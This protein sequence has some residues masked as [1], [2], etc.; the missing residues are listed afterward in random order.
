RYYDPY[1]GTWLGRDKNAETGGPNPYCFVFNNPIGF[2]DDLGNDP[3]LKIPDPS[4]SCIPLP[5]GP[6]RDFTAAQRC[7][8]NEIGN[9]EGCWE[10]GRKVP[11]TA[12]GNWF[13]DHQPANAL[14]AEGKPQFGYAH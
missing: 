12:S 6:S 10:C 2:Y 11:G 8:I 9:S 7:R 14:N 1:N 4:K 13:I 3:N 5:E